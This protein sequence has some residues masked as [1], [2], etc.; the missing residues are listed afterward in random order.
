MQRKERA[1]W[2]ENSGVGWPGGVTR[3]GSGAK[4]LNKNRRLQ[5]KL[6]RRKGRTSGRQEAFPRAAVVEPPVGS[7]Q[8]AAVLFVLSASCWLPA[9]DSRTSVAK[10]LR[11][12]HQVQISSGG[13]RTRPNKSG[14]FLCPLELQKSSPYTHLSGLPSKEPVLPFKCTAPVI[15]LL[16]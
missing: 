1:M 7:V 6:G 14:H 2:R 12:G 5:R 13:S 9:S 8:D 3:Q 15:C 11:P 16:C 4:R 10:P